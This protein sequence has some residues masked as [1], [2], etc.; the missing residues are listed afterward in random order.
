L[1]AET[2]VALSLQPALCIHLQTA[3]DNLTKQGLVMPIID[4]STITKIQPPQDALTAATSSASLRGSAIPNGV[5]R[6]EWSSLQQTQNSHSQLP[7]SSRS[8]SDF[9]SQIALV[10]G[11]FTKLRTDLAA[12]R[13]VIARSAHMLVTGALF[14]TSSGSNVSANAQSIVDNVDFLGQLPPRLG[15]LIE[16]GVGGV[17]D[18]DLFEECLA[19]NDAVARVLEIAVPIV[20]EIETQAAAFGST[21]V[22]LLPP[23]SRKYPALSDLTSFDVKVSTSTSTTTQSSQSVVKTTEK[24]KDKEQKEDSKSQS[25]SVIPVNSLSDDLMGLSFPPTPTLSSLADLNDRGRSI[26]RIDFEPSPFDANVSLS[27]A[28][29]GGSSSSSGFSILQQS[30]NTAVSSL[31]QSSSTNTTTSSQIN[32][33]IDF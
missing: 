29:E 2:L 11:A 20:E 30:R 8:E 24:E 1:I 6:P 25:Q 15:A 3:A 7:L 28:G 10:D 17:L 4:V 21:T 16:A 12:T 19:V 18:E 14:R 32:G 5:V 13:G 26:N 31:P 27:T 23:P 22:S 33:G 9:A